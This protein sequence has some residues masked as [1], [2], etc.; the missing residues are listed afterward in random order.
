MNR[1]IYV[2]TL[3]VATALGMASQVSVGQTVESA[4]ADLGEIVVTARRVEE[5]AQDVPISMTLFSQRQLT[6]R[7]IV[8]SGDLAAATPSM[9]VDNGFGDDTTSF[10]IRGFVQT[11]QATP[12]VAVY[13]ADA[14]VP[15][16]GN[17][18]VAAGSGVPTGSFFDLQNV[19]VLKG[20]QGTLFGRNTDG[21][22]VLLVPQKPTT[23]FEGYVEGSFGNYDMRQIQGVL[24]L[25]LSDT[26]RLRLAVNDETRNGYENNVSGIGPSNFENIDF[27]AARL[28]LVMDL[29]PNLENYTVGAYNL[30]VNNGLLP[31]VFACNS[32][33][34]AG[35]TLCPATLAALAGKGDY[36]VANTVPNAESYLKQIQV[37][38]T[39]SWR[40][41]DA[42]TVKNIAN[43]GEL[44]TALD[45]GL[46]GAYILQEPGVSGYI[47]Y[48]TS[49]D[50]PS[51]IGA[52]TTDQYTW[53]D[54]VQLS[55]N[56]MDGK[57]VWQGG[58]Y[59]ERSGPLGDLTGGR[60][61][62]FLI[63]PDLASFLC[64]G[65][66]I[67]DEN[68]ATIHF[69]DEALFGQASYTITDQLKIT[70]G[71][72][73]TWD[74]TTAKVNSTDYAGFPTYV[75]G[76]YEYSFCSSAYA[77]TAN[78]CESAYG[79]SSKA[80]TG[81]VDLD[82]HPT[83]DVLVY[84]KYARGY[85]QGGVATFVADGYHIYGP[86]HVDSYELGEKTTFTGPIRGTFDVTGHYNNFS[87]QQLL[88]GFLGADVS[89]SSGI[90]NAGKSR[91]WGIEIESTLQPIDPI[92]L[93]L[94]YSYLNTKLLTAFAEL[95]PGGAYTEIEFPTTVGAVLPFSPKN[96]LSAN[97]AYHLPLPDSVGKVSVAANYTYTS[98]M[99]ISATAAP[100]DTLGSYG[101]LGANLHWDDILS[102]RVDG[103][104]F[105]TNLTDKLY[106]TNL[107]ALYST[108]FG[109]AARFPGEPRMYGMR[110]RVRFGK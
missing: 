71:V 108:A 33:E 13:F 106:Y 21:G 105:V 73:Y 68:L 42:L 80:P 17:V 4:S 64:S 54:E 45:S 38:N 109:L 76:T 104:F 98:S 85:R 25:P 77:T 16:G 89:P 97:A 62:N 39:T 35:T 69:N 74:R 26:V 30:S 32:A 92:T 99:L 31:Q 49:S 87:D 81:V 88:A 96:K 12:S 91:I 7:S 72:R 66:G 1:E 51:S 83:Q 48:L 3:A 67:V 40:A 9:Q 41:S 70:G 23:D 29:T 95:P 43:Y 11:L 36:A 102:S 100:Y 44:V 103:E 94:S 10:S 59:V 50:D 14:V 24:N 53:S 90:V 27:T 75:P 79:E 63:C 37:I 22:A 55:G 101:L 61:G 18:G 52:K 84:A 28:S 2:S 107:T 58:L 5:R 20:P 86:E 60:S 34:G 57:L 19:Q 56:A 93:G 46:F 8:T 15:R 65:P 6:D 82:Y 47:P 78:N 110:I